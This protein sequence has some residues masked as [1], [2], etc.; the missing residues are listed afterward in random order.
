MMSSTVN[1]MA[2]SVADLVKVYSGT[3]RPAL[4]RLSL[5]VA[6]G[7]IFGLLGPNGAGKTTLISILC[8]LLRPSAGSAAIFGQDVVR[9]AGSVR[10]TIGLVPQDIALYPTLTAREN[11]RYF[12][13]IQRLPRRHLEARVEEC[14]ATVGLLDQA[15]RRVA[16][17]S[18]GMKRRAN[19]AVGILH[20]PELLFLDEPTVGIDAQ[21]RNLILDRLAELNRAGMTLIYTTHYMEEV[22]QLCDD[23]AIVDCGKVI[24]RGAPHALL[25]EQDACQNLEELFLALT[26]KQLRD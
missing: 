17:F 3:T 1:D 21:S 22:Q 24:A 10:R 23:I 19:L 5:Q 8:T 15:D 9:Q 13:R 7:S 18:G 11:L 4:D 2:L 16:S 14:L 26:G 6:R 25:A 12:A 20:Q